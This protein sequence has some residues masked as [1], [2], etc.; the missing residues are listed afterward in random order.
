M[1]KKEFK[2]LNKRELVDLVY[3]MM[4]G[5]PDKEKEL[6]SVEEVREKREGM[7]YRRRFRKMLWSTLA[8][9]IVV[10]AVAALISTLFLSVI[11]VSGDSMEP[12]LSN[13][14]VILLVKTKKYSHKDLC[15]IS[16]QN[17]LLIKRVIALPGE[18]VSIDADG[19]VSVNGKVLEE[20]YVQNKCL[21]ECDI[22]FP[23]VVPDGKLFVMGD[24]RD[25]SIDSRS[26]VIGC[27]DYDQ[28]VGR[29]LFRI[30]KG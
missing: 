19:N 24:K 6:P 8:A 10:A 23:Y 4:E 3:N 17:K 1:D 18:T 25:T 29:V 15:C 14:D 27:V 28:M 26:S 12:T 20:S 2:D 16:W 21:G 13:G 22:E 9:L 30:W 11:Q 5:E 7:N